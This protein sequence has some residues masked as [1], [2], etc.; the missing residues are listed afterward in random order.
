MDATLESLFNLY[1]FTTGR[2]LFALQ[3]VR[4][5]AKEQR[6][7]E[8]V[9]HCDAAVEHDLATR[10][11]ERRWAGEPVA[12]GTNPAAQRI[13]VLVDRT[14][15]AIRDH[16]VAQ[17]QGAAP[18]D[19]I[20]KEVASFLKPI[21]PVSVQAITSLPYIDELA[22]VDD[23]VALL[24]GELAPAAKEFG[25]GR[26]VTRLADL[27]VQYRE[28]LEAPPP[29]LIDWGRVRAARAEGQ[30]LL[31]EAVAIILGKHHARTREGT[32]AR[33]ALLAPIL[34]QN[35][36]IGHYLRSRRAIADVNPE[37]GED[38]P[39]APATPA[40]PQAPSEPEQPPID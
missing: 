8:L 10:A 5:L 19:P 13:D 23:I 3:K 40:A 37:T 16:V 7:T 28:A 33:L 6:F 26:L 20:H 21:F 12:S 9:K 35:E 31:L 30:G 39:A 32:A 34:Q 25:L 2:R 22:A 24:K 38:E 36:A 14:L 15:G 27:A 11:L 18:D 1:V 4:A 29:S 17:T